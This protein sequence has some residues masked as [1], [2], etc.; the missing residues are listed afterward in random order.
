M[1][2]ALIVISY[3]RKKRLYQVEGK[4]VA[5]GC[6]GKC[7]GYHFSGL[8]YPAALRSRQIFLA[9]TPVRGESV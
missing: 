3:S 8:F 1:K 7:T 2:A 5:N 9:P 4:N 6:T